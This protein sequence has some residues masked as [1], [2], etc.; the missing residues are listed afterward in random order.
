MTFVKLREMANDAE[1]LYALG[2]LYDCED[3]NL[4]SAYIS[5]KDGDQV[6]SDLCTK[7]LSIRTQSKMYNKVLSDC[8]KE[9]PI[10]ALRINLDVVDIN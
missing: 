5:C 6:F 4:V 2:E 1:I 7:L 8:V 10:A 3:M 9:F